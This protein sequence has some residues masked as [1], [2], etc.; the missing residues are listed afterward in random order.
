MGVVS[1]ELAQ[2]GDVFLRDDP[3]TV[4]VRDRHMR[5]VC[6]SPIWNA[7]RFFNV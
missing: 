2:E 7:S 1:N 5:S 3:A 6:Q 4:L